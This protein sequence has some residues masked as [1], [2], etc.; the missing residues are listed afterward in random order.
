MNQRL[1]ETLEGGH[2]AN[3]RGQAVSTMIALELNS[4]Y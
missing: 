2:I 1:A 4:G 3:S